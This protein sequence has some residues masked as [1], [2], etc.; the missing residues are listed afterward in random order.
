MALSEK[1]SALNSNNKA[2]PFQENVFGVSW[3]RQFPQEKNFKV[4][5]KTWFDVF[6]TFFVFFK[7]RHIKHLGTYEELSAHPCFF[8]GCLLCGHLHNLQSWNEE[9]AYRFAGNRKKYGK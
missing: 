3:Q 7:H 6:K 8:L 4:P 2:F 9:F 5:P 1:L